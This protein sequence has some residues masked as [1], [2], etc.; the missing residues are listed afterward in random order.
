M[1]KLTTRRSEQVEANSMSKLTT[2]QSNW[3]TDASHVMTTHRE[4]F[5]SRDC[6]HPCSSGVSTQHAPLVSLG[7]QDHKRC[8]AQDRT[9]CR[10]GDTGRRIDSYQTLHANSKDSHVISRILMLASR[11]PMRTSRIRNLP[12][13]PLFPTS[14]ALPTTSWQMATLAA[15]KGW[16]PIWPQ[17]VCR[18]SWRCL[19]Q[20][21]CCSLCLSL[22]HHFGRSLCHHCSL[23]RHFGRSLRFRWDFRH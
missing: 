19:W 8:H 20:R 13:S 23:C 6:A 10:A 5:S 16:K 3:L 2:S 11:I 12:S 15:T 21:L 4:G 14:P 7:D 18:I 17:T 22:C 1:S 9:P